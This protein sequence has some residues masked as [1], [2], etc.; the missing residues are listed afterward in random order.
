MFISID[1]SSRVQILFD[2][3]HLH[4]ITLLQWMLQCNKFYVYSVVRNVLLILEYV[5]C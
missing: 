2:L 5:H 3:I 1:V 4:K